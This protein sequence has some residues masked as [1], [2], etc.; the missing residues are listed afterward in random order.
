MRQLLRVIP[1]GLGLISPQENALIRQWGE[2]AFG[3]L[4]IC[5]AFQYHN[6]SD[7]CVLAYCEE[8]LVGFSAVFRRKVYIDGFLVSMACVGGVITRPESRGKGYGRL[9]MHEIHRLIYRTLDCQAGGLLCEKS[10]APF[11]E[12]VGWTR[13]HEPA[14]VEQGGKKTEWPEAFMY[15]S[16]SDKIKASSKF[17]LCGKP[18]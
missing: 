3:N 2:E 1:H 15:H 7:Y 8:E 11:Y 18:W 4:A 12:K 10:T 17:D 6:G 14:L 16:E 13:C 5:S 9:M